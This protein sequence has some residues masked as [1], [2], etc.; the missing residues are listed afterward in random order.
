MTTFQ[1]L[2]T[3]HMSSTQQTIYQYFKIKTSVKKTKIYL[4]QIFIIIVK[5]GPR[6]TSLT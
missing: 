6:A 3:K 1:I 4:K 2:C 5:K